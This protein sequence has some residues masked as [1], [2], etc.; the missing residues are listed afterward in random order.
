MVNGF[1]RL[2]TIGEKAIFARQTI[3][4]E[5]M[6]PRRGEGGRAGESGYSSPNSMPTERA[7][8]T[9]SPLGSAVFIFPM[10]SARS[11]N[12]ILRSARTARTPDPAY[13]WEPQKV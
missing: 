6:V 13:P 1:V 9:S 7:A 4:T 2:Q 3:T 8:L 12:S 11:T 10:V 5:V